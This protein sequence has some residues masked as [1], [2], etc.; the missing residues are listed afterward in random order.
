MQYD[1]N[2]K[3]NKRA[4]KT[5]ALPDAV[6]SAAGENGAVKSA[7]GKSTDGRKDAGRRPYGRYLLTALWGIFTVFTVVLFFAERYLMDS[8][9][10]LSADEV[11]YHLK[12]SLDGTN[13]EMI[14]GALIHYGLPAAVVIAAITAVLYRLGKKGRGRAA[15]MAA[16]LALDFAALFF[17]KTELDRRLNFT[18]Y[19]SWTLFG[20]NSDFIADNYVDPGTVT[21]TFPEKKRNLIFIF[22]ES[23]EMT[24][25]DRESG[26]AFD[27][28]VIPELT[29]LAM[30][31][32]DFSGNEAVLNGGISLPGSTWTMG[33]MFAMATGAP[34]KVPIKG[35]SIRDEKHFFPEM[36]SL[37]TILEKQGYRQELLIGSKASFGGRNVF[38]KG[39][40][41]FEIRDYVH[42]ARYRR[43]PENYMVFWGYE[44]EKLFELAR[45]DLTE[46]ASAKRPFNLTMLTVDTHFE[47]G[48]R[49][50]LC[51]DD[52][53]EQYAD[54][55]ACSSRQVTEF[56]EWVKQQDFYPDTT[57]VICGDHPTMD[58]DFCTDVPEDYLRKTYVAIINGKNPDSGTGST[59]YREY[60]TMDM[61]PTTLAAMGV[62]IEGN[63]L[64]LGTNL[65]SE[66]KTLIEEYGLEECETELTL[67]SAFMDKMS[68]IRITKELLEEISGHVTIGAEY[69][70]NGRV[71]LSLNKLCDYLNYESVS[72]VELEIRDEAAGKKETFSLQPAFASLEDKNQYSYSKLYDL[73]GRNLEDLKVAFYITTE[74]FKHYKVADL[75][76]NLEESEG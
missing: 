46:M 43:I 31:N 51:R 16:V 21:I 63:R 44:D 49:C 59:A 73:E 42:A 57:I 33:A 8:W 24:F 45:E 15:F 30:E 62:Q 64:G 37:G 12:S 56:V 75:E 22:L 4:E 50:R 40:G 39:H 70:D 48:Y 9:A 11:V 34:L 2:S 55:F 36:K 25:A 5:D 66:E 71:R 10:E 28:N 58:K 26:G 35:N 76:N 23:T 19:F 52:F 67:P 7:A 6:K 20:T 68:G 61:F 60:S 38:Y 74:G 32:E 47:D 54:A 69:D 72:E 1:N 3:N 29:E 14:I 41:N 65:Y 13:P 18:N 53:G 27:K 17:V